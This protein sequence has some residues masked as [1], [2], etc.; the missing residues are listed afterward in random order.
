[1]FGFDFRQGLEECLVDGAK[2][3][4]DKL[5]A[6]AGSLP[7]PDRP[8][9]P[10]H[11]HRDTPPRGSA[12]DCPGSNRDF[13]GLYATLQTLSLLPCVLLFPIP[14]PFKYDGE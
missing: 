6:G 8:Q 4:L 1:M 7:T 2:A 9:D 10:A 3:V 12:S 11:A 5:Q 14:R 13:K